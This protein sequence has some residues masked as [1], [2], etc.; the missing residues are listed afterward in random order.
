MEKTRPVYYFYGEEDYFIEEALKALK[1]QALTKGFESLNYHVYEAKTLEASQVVEAALTMPAFSAMRLIIVNGAEELGKEEAKEFLEYA[2]SPSP[3]TCM[4]FVA[5]GRKVDWGSELFKYLRERGCVKEYKGLKGDELEGW[6]KEYAMREGKSITP[7]AIGRLL[8]IAGEN[9]RD[10]KGELDKVIIFAGGAKSIE[11]DDIESCAYPVRYSTAFD[12]ADAIGRKDMGGAIRAL[13]HLTEEE[14]LMILGAIAWHFRI[15][16]KIKA[17]QRKG[18]ERGR[19]AGLARVSRDKLD[20][21]IRGSKNLSEG[22]LLGILVRLNSANIEFKSGRL[23]DGL[24][25]T[26]LIMELCG[27]GKTRLNRLVF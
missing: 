16:L 7:S 2:K 19:L 4:V 20:T 24:L 13:S 3:T 11:E 17:Y 8:A 9:L 15:L 10:V 26:N 27:R 23:A 5:G 22:E 18:A 12:L 1:G 14:P 25:L 21:Y 6:V